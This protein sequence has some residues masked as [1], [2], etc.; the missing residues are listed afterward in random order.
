MSISC[1]INMRFLIEFITR[2]LAIA[3]WEIHAQDGETKKKVF[4]SR[5][6][7]VSNPLGW[8][9]QTVPINSSVFRDVIN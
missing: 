7:R 3:N 8:H 1:S 4:E 6:L 9:T 2:Y 5:G